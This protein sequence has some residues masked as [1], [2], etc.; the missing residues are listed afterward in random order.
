MNY[1]WN[2]KKVKKMR[3]VELISTTPNK[4]ATLENNASS[5]E[6]VTKGNTDVCDEN[7]IIGAPKDTLEDQPRIVEK[8]ISSTAYDDQIN[9]L[10]QKILILETESKLNMERFSNERESMLEERSMAELKFHYASEQLDESRE[11]ESALKIIIEETTNELESAQDEFQKLSKTKEQESADF[12]RELEEKDRHIVDQK[13]DLSCKDRRLE[14]ASVQLSELEMELFDRDEE[15]D[16]LNAKRQHIQDNASKQLV[17]MEKALEK[18]G[19]EIDLLE[20][21]KSKLQNSIQNYEGQIEKQLGRLS[22]ASLQLSELEN[23]LFAKDDDFEEIQLEINAM[24][25]LETQRLE[26]LKGSENEKRIL[27]EQ[28][29]NANKRIEN[30]VSQI[31]AIKEENG[32]ERTETQRI[33]SEEKRKD[34][35]LL[36]SKSQVNRQLQNVSKLTEQNDKWQLQLEKAG[37]EKQELIENLAGVTREVNSLRKELEEANEKVKELNTIQA[38]LSDDLDC[39]IEEEKKNLRRISQ[40]EEQK[41]TLS[42]KLE[43]AMDNLADLKKCYNESQERVVSLGDGIIEKL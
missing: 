34:K 33:L 15:I 16:R 18:E 28:L 38:G 19:E 31:E 21:E 8:E 24:Q 29:K 2:N 10:E 23:E 1:P 20:K 6:T 22:E 37:D 27:K 26:A 39:A 32:A 4:V 35:E 3:L 25:A 14:Q 42:V 12:R 11:R 17:E 36:S 40:L 9:H 43:S 41:E 30:L 7:T 13:N 5:E